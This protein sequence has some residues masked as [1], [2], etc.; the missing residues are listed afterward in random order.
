MAQDA[1]ALPGGRSREG[2]LPGLPSLLPWLA[3][4][5]WWTGTPLPLDLILVLVPLLAQVCCPCS[6]P[7]DPGA[8]AEPH[9]LQVNRP[10]PREARGV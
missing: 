8:L 6:E 10:R 7:N 3:A 4:S 1:S 2:A 9:L 5:L